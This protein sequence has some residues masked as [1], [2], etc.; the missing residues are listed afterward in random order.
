MSVDKK[1]D[2]PAFRAHIKQIF[3]RT[4]ESQI[5][6]INV[7]E[8]SK[9]KIFER[10]DFLV[11]GIFDKIV[12][13]A[14]YEEGNE[15]LPRTKYDAEYFTKLNN[16]IK[17]AITDCRFTLTDLNLYRVDIKDTFDSAE[18]SV[19]DGFGVR[20]RKRKVVRGK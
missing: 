12:K 15:G 19:L 2:D 9:D 18:T 3:K 8:K 5:D 13:N 20:G 16:E 11:R 6:I 7:I 1:S 4:L 17:K 10:Q 14:K